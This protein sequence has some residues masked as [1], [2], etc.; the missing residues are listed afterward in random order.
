M[1]KINLLVLLMLGTGLLLQQAC[2]KECNE[3]ILKENLTITNEFKMLEMLTEDF[4]V[5]ISDS[6]IYSGNQVKAVSNFNFAHSEWYVNGNIMK[7]N[8][9]DSII[10]LP[11]EN[12]NIKHVG[13]SPLNY[14][15]FNLK[16]DTTPYIG[17][18][19]LLDYR[20]LRKNYDIRAPFS[21]NFKYSGN[22]ECR[23]SINK[24][25]KMKIIDTTLDNSHLMFIKL[26]IEFLPDFYITKY[27]V[28]GF[29]SDL[30]TDFLY[31]KNYYDAF[32]YG[33]FKNDKLK[34]RIILKGEDINEKRT[35]KQINLYAKK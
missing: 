25:Y 22:Y 34:I 14:T 8:H 13:Y 18:I 12:H 15:N 30:H 11:F 1:K 5:P 4:G 28:N 21:M 33:T 29:Y 7:R 16:I 24:I 27:A 9:S 20:K 3:R 23:D 32:L 31:D 10:Y 26:G 2:K 19:K 6:K 17:F 35:I